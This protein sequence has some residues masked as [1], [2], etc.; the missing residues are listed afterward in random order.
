MTGGPGLA[1]YAA[2]PPP[3]GSLFD[4]YKRLRFRLVLT[5]GSRLTPHVVSR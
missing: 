2:S 3:T 1:G 4:S 5:S